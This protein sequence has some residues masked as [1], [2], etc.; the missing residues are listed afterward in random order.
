MGDKHIHQEC[1]LEA[2]GQYGGERASE[3]ERCAV[4]VLPSLG[5]PTRGGP[6]APRGGV[7]VPE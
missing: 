3:T 2:L 1:V 6:V 7:Q 5:Y 4:N